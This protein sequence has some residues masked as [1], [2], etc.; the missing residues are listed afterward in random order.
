MVLTLGRL[1]EHESV[2]SKLVSGAARTVAVEDST[3]SSARSCSL[4]GVFLVF[5]ALDLLSFG[6][7]SPVF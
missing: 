1:P 7:Q 5:R 3:L 6:E 2:H 4:S